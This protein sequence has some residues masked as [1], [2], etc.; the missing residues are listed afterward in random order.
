MTVNM[1]HNIDDFLMSMTTGTLRS[2]ERAQSRRWPIFGTVGDGE[3]PELAQ[4]QA[5]NYTEPWH[6]SCVLE[7]CKSCWKPNEPFSRT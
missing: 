4:V 1:H 5:A 2:L 3:K 6:K 7:D